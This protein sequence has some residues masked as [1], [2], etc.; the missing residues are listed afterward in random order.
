M[1]GEAS[2]GREAVR[3]ALELL[4]DVAILDV[5]MPLIP[6]SPYIHGIPGSSTKRPDRATIMAQAVSI[7]RAAFVGV[8]QRP[9]RGQATM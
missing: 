2:D 7:M 4:P 6:M 9:T 1:V 8:T 5:A 3:L